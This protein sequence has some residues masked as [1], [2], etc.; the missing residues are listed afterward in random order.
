MPAL[1]T[2]TSGPC[3]ISSTTGRA[4]VLTDYKARRVSIPTRT[5]IHGDTTMLAA[6][7][8]LSHVGERIR[9]LPYLALERLVFTV[10]G[11]LIH[12]TVVEVGA[13]RF[14]ISGWYDVSQPEN[15]ALRKAVPAHPWHGE[16]NVVALGMVQPYLSTIPPS[17]VRIAI[18]KFMRDFL[19]NMND[20]PTTIE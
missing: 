4:Y 9:K 12:D 1:R 3:T 19:D 7:T 15:G 17:V 8:S 5:A 11:V 16:I 10:K 13:K 18:K 20:I 6:N 2:R 14:L